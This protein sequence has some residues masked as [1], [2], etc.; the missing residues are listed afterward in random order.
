MKEIIEWIFNIWTLYWGDGFYQYLLLASVLYLLVK[1]RRDFRIGPLLLYTLCALLIFVFPVTAWAIGKCIGQGVYWRT[2]WLVPTV[3]II[4]IAAADLVR[5]KKRWARI[6]LMAVLVCMIVVCGR[7]MTDAGNYVLAHNYQQVP[8]EVAQI[9]N[10]IRQDAGESEV[11]LATDDHVASYA[12]IYDPSFYM[13]YG[14]SGRGVRGK[15]GRAL[16]EEIIAGGDFTKIASLAKKLECNYIAV[17]MPDSEKKIYFE[18]KG[19]YEI[20]TSNYYRIFALR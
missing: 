7:S 8:D 9:C 14:R 6:F 1:K 2:L 18:E 3:P 5:N 4:A 20:G 11:C 15:R 10:I 19:Y 17:I 12:R 13:P 16:Y